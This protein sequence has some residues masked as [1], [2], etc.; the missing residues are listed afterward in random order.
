MI[1]CYWQKCSCGLRLAASN[2]ERRAR[3]RLDILVAGTLIRFIEDCRQRGKC[4]LFSTHNMS[5]VE[6]LCDR[7]GIIHDGRLRASGTLDELRELT[8]K[9]YLEE[10]FVSLMDRG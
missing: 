9:E 2:G 8:S 5:E 6:R 1:R 10:I 4:V 3:E 7:I